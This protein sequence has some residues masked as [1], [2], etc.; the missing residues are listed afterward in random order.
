VPI[1]ELDP[2]THLTAD[3]VG[4]PGRRTFFLQAASG[5]EQVTLLMEKEQVRVL[6]ERL[7]GWL[8]RLAA[9]RPEDPNEVAAAEAS[10]MGLR[11]PLVADFRVGQLTLAYDPERDRVVI[12]AAELTEDADPDENPDPDEAPDQR[13][14]R[15]VATR[16]QLRAL[17]RHGSEVVARGRPT[18]PL[19]GNA[20]DPGG[21]VC[22][23]MN[24]HRP[25]AS[26]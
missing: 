10:P 13:Q 11:E 3:A 14:V 17:A 9:D 22:P 21:H 2:L 23:A 4:E 18:C 12:T 15:L 6:A 25:F 8:P 20:M 16:P 5:V 26:G 19:C 24:G 7:D 1:H